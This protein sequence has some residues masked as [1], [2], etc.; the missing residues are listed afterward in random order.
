ARRYGGLIARLPF[1]RMVAV[2]GSL[3]VDNADE[4]DDLDFLI[5]TAPGRVWLT[6]AMVMAVGRLASLRGI[7]LCPNDLSAETALE[8]PDRDF[9]TARELLQMRLIAGT[10]TYIRMLETNAWWRD[11]LPN[12]EPDLAGHGSGKPDATGSRPSFL[13]GASEAFLRL[14]PFDALE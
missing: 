3:A 8:L 4:D 1:V 5:V 14:P 10:A 2:T 13:R 9:Y 11:F 12:A 7:T 6:R